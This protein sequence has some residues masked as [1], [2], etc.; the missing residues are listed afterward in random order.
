[1][2]WFEIVYLIIMTIG[3]TFTI[4]ATGALSNCDRRG[5][6][7]DAIFLHH[8]T[9]LGRKKFN[10]LYS[11]EFDDIRDFHGI[12]DYLP[13]NWSYKRLLPADKYEIIKPYLNIVKGKKNA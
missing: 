2:N 5:N 4:S 12:W 13:W 9:C 6:L 10:E 8:I 1:M 7:I 3:V 11:V